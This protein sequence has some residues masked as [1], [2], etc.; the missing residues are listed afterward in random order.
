MKIYENLDLDDLEN[1]IWKDIKDFEGL[2]QVSNFG[3]IK[4]FIK[5]HGVNTRI[6][7]QSKNSNGYFKT[8]LS[9]NK[10]RYYKK[11]HILVYEAFYN[12]KLKNNECV[13]HKDKIKDNNHHENLEKMTK[14]NHKKFHMTGSNNLNFGKNLSGEN[15]PHHKLTEEQVIQI[16][17][18]LL[19]GKLT[20]QEIANMFNTSRQIVYLIKNEKIWKHVKI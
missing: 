4:S 17:I 19:E 3:R 15:N 1:E 13:H 18:L 9:K 2:Y 8:T 11:V 6:I 20:Q 14:Y 12:D 7:K 16:K 5:Y 10:K